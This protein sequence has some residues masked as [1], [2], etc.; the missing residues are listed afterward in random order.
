MAQA[1]CR[2]SLSN[3]ANPM[4]LPKG[5]LLVKHRSAEEQ[6][7]PKRELKADKRFVARLV[8]SRSLDCLHSSHPKRL[9]DAIA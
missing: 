2:Q 6:I 5:L 1:L 4:K 9:C 3:P 7:T 8:E